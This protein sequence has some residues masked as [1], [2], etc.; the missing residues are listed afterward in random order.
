MIYHLYL[1]DQYVEYAINL[2]ALITFVDKLI[3]FI[4]NS[5]DME[6]LL[7]PSGDTSK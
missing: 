5:Q 3:L 6:V 4:K 1:L 2:Y 7:K